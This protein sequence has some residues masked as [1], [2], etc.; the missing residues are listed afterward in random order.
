M[1]DDEVEDLLYQLTFLR[2]PQITEAVKEAENAPEKRI[3]QSLLA[4][5]VVGM[6]HGEDALKSVEGSTSAFFSLRIDEVLKMTKQEFMEH[7][8]HTDVVHID[9]I[10]R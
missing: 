2:S 7:F 5:K 6:I 8:A 9:G 4:K 3:G 10:N 1:Q